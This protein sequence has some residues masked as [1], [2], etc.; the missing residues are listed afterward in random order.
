[1][2][3]F[4]NNIEES[5]YRTDYSPNSYIFRIKNILLN[6]NE[7]N[8]ETIE[9][10]NY[11]LNL[12][13]TKRYV[14][15]QKQIWFQEAKCDG[16]LWKAVFNRLNQYFKESKIIRN[17]SKSINKTLEIDNSIMWT[18]TSLNSKLDEIKF[19][20]KKNKDNPFSKKLIDLI[21]NRLYKEFQQEIW[22][23]LDVCDWKLW[24]DSL[25]KMIE[26]FNPTFFWKDLSEI[27]SYPMIWDRRNYHCSET[28]RKNWLKFWLELPR[29]NAYMAGKDPGI[30]V[31]QYL[32]KNS[33]WKKP[34]ATR[35]E[36]PLEDFYNCD[37]SA[38]FI[39]FFAYSHNS[40]G[41][42]AVAFKDSTWQR[43][44][45][46]PYI[47]VN[48]RKNLSPTRIEDYIKKRKIIKAHFYHATWFVA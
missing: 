18:E 41:H 5:V 21:N 11:L 39:D 37:D 4:R 42:R 20:L 3:E 19:I 47:R 7:D 23:K 44:V 15:F 17:T 48:W 30:G 13:E 8:I 45:L 34:Q 2:R 24:R 28:A 43:Y 29:W 14:E 38:N 6:Q 32:P 16:K 35:D 22:L 26:Y 36:I 10:K 46:D 12:L 33:K 40:Y 27:E 31:I 1:M 25:L 9:K